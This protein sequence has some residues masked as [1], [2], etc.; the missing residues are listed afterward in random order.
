MRKLPYVIAAAL[1]MP[2]A[3]Q[4]Q[5]LDRATQRLELAANRAQAPG[6]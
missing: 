4:A 1:A 5:E 3:A 6:G 2:A